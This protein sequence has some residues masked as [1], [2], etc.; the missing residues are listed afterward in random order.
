MVNLPPPLTGIRS[1][2]R[3]AGSELLYRLSYPGPQV[4]HAYVS[5]IMEEQL[6]MTKFY[7][8]PK[9]EKQWNVLNTD[10]RE[11]TK[12]LFESN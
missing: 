10:T 2:D 4:V 6:T 9:K 12:C 5:M 1:Q 8:P 7:L 3:A 11:E